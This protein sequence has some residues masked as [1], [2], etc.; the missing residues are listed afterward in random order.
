M[1]NTIEVKKAQAKPLKPRTKQPQQPLPVN[2][3]QPEIW[4]G[5]NAGWTLVTYKRKKKGNNRK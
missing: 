5:N 1:D 2:G 4:D 3:F